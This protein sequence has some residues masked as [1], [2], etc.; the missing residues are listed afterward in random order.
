MEHFIILHLIILAL[1]SFQDKTRSYLLQD[2]KSL[3]YTEPKWFLKNCF[4]IFA[5]KSIPKY[6]LSCSCILVSKKS[7]GKYRVPR[8][9]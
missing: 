1:A 4:A 8:T 3:S 7:D 2:S 6:F 5:L 9:G